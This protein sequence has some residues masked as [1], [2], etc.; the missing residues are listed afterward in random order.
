MLGLRYN[1][2]LATL[3]TLLETFKTLDAVTQES[4]MAILSHTKPRELSKRSLVTVLLV[5]FVI[6]DEEDDT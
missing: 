5:M 2:I 6:M 4:Q 3:F 1:G